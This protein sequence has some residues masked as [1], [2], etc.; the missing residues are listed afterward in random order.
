MDEPEGDAA[1]LEVVPDREL[2]SSA[3]LRSRLLIPVIASLESDLELEE[4]EDRITSITHLWGDEADPL[5]VREVVPVD[6][7]QTSPEGN[8]VIMH[9]LSQ[10]AHEGP[11][12]AFQEVMAIMHPNRRVLAVESD[13]MGEFS[14]SLTLLDLREIMDYTIDRMAERRLKF[15]EALSATDEPTTLIDTSM[16]TLIT[17]MA[18]KKAADREIQLKIDNVILSDSAIVTKSRKP[19][20]LGFLAHMPAAVVMELYHGV[21]NDHINHPQMFKTGVRAL[22]ALGLKDVLAITRQAYDVFFGKHMD[23]PG[24]IHTFNSFPSTQFTCVSGTGDTLRTPRQYALWKQSAAHGNVHIR[25]V[26]WVG[27]GRSVNFEQLSI[28]TSNALHRYDKRHYPLPHYPNA[29]VTTT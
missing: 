24:M 28:D 27:H 9:G 4:Y 26:P 2:D 29:T 7:E 12:A 3:E 11:S 19:R 5:V 25:E 13:N 20:M 8:I 10:L 15:L 21:K 1:L 16:G 18:L 22:S 17:M 6:S 14:E 23:D